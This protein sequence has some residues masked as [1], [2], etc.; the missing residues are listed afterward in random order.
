MLLIIITSTDR[1][2]A[3]VLYPPTLILC[4]HFTV[5]YYFRAPFMRD[6][7]NPELTVFTCYEKHIFELIVVYQSHFISKLRLEHHDA[8]TTFFNVTQAD[9][10][11]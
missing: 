4:I 9:V 5:I 10:P 7:P 11:L 8:L 6:F 2:F 3:L 1:G